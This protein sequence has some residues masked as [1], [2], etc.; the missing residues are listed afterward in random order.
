MDEILT[1]QRAS[2]FVENSYYSP[3]KQ[4]KVNV[5]A[6]F[7]S[8]EWLIPHIIGEHLTLLSLLL[9]TAKTVYDYTTS[10]WFCSF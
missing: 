6:K 3:Y 8:L 10:E 7:K 1:L 2:V 9:W 5:K 4:N